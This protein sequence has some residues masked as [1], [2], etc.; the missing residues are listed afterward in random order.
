MQKLFFTLLSLLLLL[1]NIQA[2]ETLKNSSIAVQ[3]EIDTEAPFTFN[4]LFRYDTTTHILYA[5]DD[6]EWKPLADGVTVLEQDTV[7]TVIYKEAHSFDLNTY[8]VP[9]LPV[10]VGFDPANASHIDSVHFTYV[11]ATPNIDSIQIQT[12]GLLD[13]GAHGFTAGEIYYLTDVNGVYST[14]PGTVNTPVFL[15]VDATKIDLLEQGA[16]ETK[17]IPRFIVSSALISSLGGDPLAPHDS[18]MQNVAE[19]Y[20][21]A[22]RA[23]PGSMFITNGTPSL[24]PTYDPPIITGDEPQPYSP[25][26]VWYWDGKQVTK[27]EYLLVSIDLQ[28]T[29]WGGLGTNTLD[30]VLL[31]N[32]LPTDSLVSEWYKT[33]YENNGL[34]LRNGTLLYWIGDGTITNPNYVWSIIDDLSANIAGLTDYEKIIKRIKSP[35][36]ASNSIPDNLPNE[37]VTVNSTND[38]KI[39]TTGGVVLGTASLGGAYSFSY[40]STAEDGTWSYPFDAGKGYSDGAGS[41]AIEAL[42]Y[43]TWFSDGFN[44]ASN[45]GAFM[46]VDHG[47]STT[48][49][50][51]VRTGVYEGATIRTGTLANARF[52]IGNAA[53]TVPD[54]ILL[55]YAYDAQNPLTN[56]DF[57]SLVIGS[58]I[59]TDNS[60]NSPFG[61]NRRFSFTQWRNGA[62]NSSTYDWLSIDIAADT[63]GNRVSFYNDSYALANAIPGAN[64]I[65]YWPT[66][67]TPAFTDGPLA[68][69]LDAGNYKIT[70]GNS[71]DLETTSS[72]IL[73]DKDGNDNYFHAEVDVANQ[74]IN[75]GDPFD[76]N[77]GTL[78]QVDGDADRI[79]ISGVVNFKHRLDFNA[80][81]S[82][83]LLTGTGVPEGNIGRERGSLYLQTDGTGTSLWVK[84]G[85]GL[86]SVGWTAISG[87]SGG[88]SIATD[89]TTG[90]VN[91][92]GGNNLLQIQTTGNFEV[93]N[94]SGGDFMRHSGNTL[95]LLHNTGGYMTLGTGATPYIDF[96]PSSGGYFYGDHTQIDFGS[97]FTGTDRRQGT[98]L[99]DNGG[100]SV[101]ARKR[102]NSGDGKGYIMRL[103]SNSDILGGHS[104]MSMERAR[105]TSLTN[106]GNL[107]VGDTLGVIE[108]KGAYNTASTSIIPLSN[109]NPVADITVLT[110]ENY[111]AS[112]RGTELFINTTASGNTDR[113]SVIKIDGNQNFNVLTK[114]TPPTVTTVQRDAL[115]GLLEGSLIYN[116]TLNRNQSYDG[117]TW[118]NTSDKKTKAMM[119]INGGSTS[120]ISGT[121][122]RFDNDAPGTTVDVFSTSDLTLS[123]SEIT[124]TGTE[125]KVVKVF[126]QISGSTSTASA[127]S[128]F[129]SQNDVEIVG[130]KMERTHG[131]SDVGFIALQWVFTISN[132]DTVSMFVDAV[133]NETFNN[134]EVNITLEE[135]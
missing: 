126:V 76:D 99:F 92:A 36:G 71:F 112:N 109:L 134:S 95:N 55:N 18:I 125:S 33:N 39:N 77:N 21:N 31:D 80:A 91:V 16:S 14:T 15:V 8:T 78:I 41:W 97:D 20:K 61:T 28:D 106:S 88:A 42:N 66:P 2:Q 70:T 38:L 129:I 93:G 32:G 69:M 89:L 17:N 37:D 10:K 7:K 98:H 127:M 23:S 117:S 63:T 101:F 24:N 120:F 59:S 43:P 72:V 40:G 65:Q 56:T 44:V 45:N 96:G 11:V 90:P 135:W 114:F 87:G 83:S 100:S 81:E 50:A 57:Y 108:W 5:W 86:N 116:S 30:T 124:Y 82:I 25:A 130:S 19:I 118:T 13:I 123:G 62:S 75:L 9:I 3:T 26:N 107:I 131:N 84:E 12:S 132:G 103:A 29:Q 111:S 54:G 105:T 74:I 67:T 133:A 60:A 102:F 113:S 22:G 6:G 35:T 85:T 115:T 68:T 94:I 64:Q 110:S 104:V 1:G 49:T 79:N 52:G 53:E 73:G 47:S 27:A 58:G 34:Q 51:D 119:R 122:E 4:P 121:A 48:N 128:Y 46:Y